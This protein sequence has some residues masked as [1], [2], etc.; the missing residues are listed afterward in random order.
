MITYAIVTTETGPKF[1][2][3]GFTAVNW[4]GTHEDCKQRISQFFKADADEGTA[5]Q[6]V[7]KSSLSDGDYYYRSENEDGTV[8]YTNVRVVQIQG[9]RV[10]I[11]L[12][13][14]S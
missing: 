3:R 5:P 7:S 6:L 10:E 4:V 13:M 11:S 9:G 2:P 1:D 12:G 8:T 14:R